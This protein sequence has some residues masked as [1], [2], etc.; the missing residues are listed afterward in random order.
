MASASPE[1]ASVGGFKRVGRFV[2]DENTKGGAPR[3]T[4]Y[5]SEENGLCVVVVNTD[6]PLVHG[7]FVIATEAHDDDGCPHTLEHL[8]FMGS[9]DYPYKGVLDCL[10]NRCLA[11]GTS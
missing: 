3:I 4:K 5:R 2:A 9:D 7:N 1:S 6:G 8:V 10:A 11:D